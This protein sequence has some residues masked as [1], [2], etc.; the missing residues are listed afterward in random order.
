MRQRRSLRPPSF[1]RAV[2]LAFIFACGGGGDSG[3]GAPAGRYDGVPVTSKKTIEHLTGPVDVV[4]D[5]YGMIHIS[6][7]NAVDGMRVQGYQV[8]RDRTA[9][10]ELIRRTATG[11]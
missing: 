8:A 5:T 7:T 6:A 9:Q 11:R 4:R 3:G 10:L 1:A 2:V